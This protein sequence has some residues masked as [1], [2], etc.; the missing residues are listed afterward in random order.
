[1]DNEN[2]RQEL[3]LKQESL[4]SLIGQDYSRRS[5]R[6]RLTELDAE[7][8]E[9]IL[10]LQNVLKKARAKQPAIL[11]KLRGTARSRLVV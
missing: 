4:T 11:K 10:Y 9:Q 6:V 5:K 7:Y 2:G 8:L 3:H 1:M